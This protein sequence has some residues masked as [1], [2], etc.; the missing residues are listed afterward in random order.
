MARKKLLAAAASAAALS[1]LIAGCSS[2]G[3]TGDA[4]AGEAKTGGILKVLSNGDLDHYDPQLSAYVPTY[5]VLRAIVRPLVSYAASTDADERIQLQPDLAEAVPTPSEDGLTYEVALREGPAWDAP[6]GARAIV[7]EDVAR[8]F[9]RMCNPVIASA[10]LSYF[11]NLI[12][13]MADFC[14]LLVRSLDAADRRRLDVLLMAADVGATAAKPSAKEH[15]VPRPLP[16]PDV[17]RHRD[18]ARRVD[19]GIGRRRSADAAPRA[20][21]RIRRGDEVGVG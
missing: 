13:G 10:Q 5:N 7:A 11:Q 18:P 20:G 12:A 15:H 6:D 16:C 17:A 19:A 21:G 8:G 3:T 9:K 1:L 2:S 14:G 4:D